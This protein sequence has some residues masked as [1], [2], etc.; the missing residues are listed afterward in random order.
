MKWLRRSDWPT[1]CSLE[2]P[3]IEYEEEW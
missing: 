3:D 2:T 1:G